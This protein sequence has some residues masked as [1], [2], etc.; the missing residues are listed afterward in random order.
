MII[1]QV[2][3]KVSCVFFESRIDAEDYLSKT[4]T[5]VNGLSLSELFVVD[6]SQPSGEDGRAG[7]CGSGEHGEGYY[8]NED[9]S[10]SFQ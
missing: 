8:R 9:G 6:A 2:Y 10:V 4:A 3:N 5:A 1:Y 7:P